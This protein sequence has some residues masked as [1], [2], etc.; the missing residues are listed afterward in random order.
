MLAP[1]QPRWNCCFLGPENPQAEREK[2]SM[3]MYEGT[4]NTVDALGDFFHTD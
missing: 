3:L 4:L 1:V 2:M